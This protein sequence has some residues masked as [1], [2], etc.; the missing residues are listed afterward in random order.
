MK[1]EGEMGFESCYV[2]EKMEGIWNVEDLGSQSVLAWE[3]RCGG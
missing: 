1:W 3:Y 2:V